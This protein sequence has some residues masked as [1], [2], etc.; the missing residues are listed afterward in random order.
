MNCK[1]LYH[2]AINEHSQRLNKVNFLVILY[3][4]AYQGNKSS[5]LRLVW[6]CLDRTVFH[7]NVAW[8]LYMF[9][10]FDAYQVRII[11]HISPIHPTQLVRHPLNSK[12]N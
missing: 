7:H 6:E 10:T 8:G 12:T 4:T 3:K 11:C 2:S 9:C 5:S 1:G